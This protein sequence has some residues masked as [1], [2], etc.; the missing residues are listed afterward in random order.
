MVSIYKKHRR[1]IFLSLFLFF[2]RHKIAKERGNY[3][4]IERLHKGINIVKGVKVRQK[5]INEE[6]IGLETN[7]GAT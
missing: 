7:E 5:Q 3:K 1:S 6:E 2:E 4:S